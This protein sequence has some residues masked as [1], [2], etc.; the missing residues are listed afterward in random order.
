MSW[1]IGA[2][3][4]GN[5]GPEP[6][7]ERAVRARQHAEAALRRAE[8]ALADGQRL[9]SGEPGR[10]YRRLADDAHLAHDLVDRC[11]QARLAS[12]WLLVEAA[13]RSAVA[14]RRIAWTH[15]RLAQAGSARAGH[16]RLLAVDYRATADI[17]DTAVGY[18]RRAA[19][20]SRDPGEP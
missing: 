17:L 20:P 9:C 4:F 7:R 1:Q 13:E 18:Y 19:G 3:G 16:H 10:A 5:A 6:A 11:Q 2:M 12:A 8:K 15:E 14:C